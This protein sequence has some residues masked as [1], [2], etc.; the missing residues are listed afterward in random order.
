M[1]YKNFKTIVLAV[2]TSTLL[3]LSGCG[4][5]GAESDSGLNTPALTVS[6]PEYVFSGDTVTLQSVLPSGSKATVLWEQLEGVTVTLDD[7][8][9]LNPTFVAPDTNT[10]STLIFE[11]TLTENGYTTKTTVSVELF[12]SQLLISAGNKQKVPS[13]NQVRLHG[14][15]NLDDGHTVEKIQWTQSD[16]DN[17]SVT[18]IDDDTFN[19][20]FTA[21]DVQQET[22][23]HFNLNVSTDFFAAEDSVT[24]TVLP[25]TVPQVATPNPIV[26]HLGG[27]VTL[28]PTVDPTVS[29]PTH[30]WTQVSGPGVTIQTPTD[31]TTSVTIDNNGTAP[32]VIAHTVTNGVTGTSTTTQHVIHIVPEIL[33]R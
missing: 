16:D 10:S 1:K 5:T 17:I 12:S 25:T 14:S 21:P 26:A 8:N 23:L 32:A 22:V 15:S 29:I 3:A 6:A 33:S 2:A 27:S 20:T 13:G 31:P 18:L 7:P 11:L 28:S 19:P 24:V 30:T 9:S 4:S